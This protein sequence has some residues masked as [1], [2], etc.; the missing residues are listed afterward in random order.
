MR[1]RIVQFEGRRY[2]VKLEP[3]W[4]ERLED[5]SQQQGLRLNQLIGHVARN[6]TEEVNLTAAIRS[7]CLSRT[8]EQ[9]NRV[10]GEL[11]E[12]SLTNQGVPL[13][14]IVDACPSPTLMVSHNQSIQRAN[15]AAVQWLGIDAAALIGR[16]I[17]HYIQ[18]KSQIPLDKILQEFE[19][20]AHH[21]YHGRIVYLRPGRVVTARAN[22]CPG[23]IDPVGGS[24][25]LLLVDR[26]PG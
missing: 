25:F 3:I 18:I 10:E 20:G 11:E 8:L 22:I 13:G 9:L 1:H 15:Q 7:Y 14:L 17:G 12:R 19:N 5:L 6:A 23:V 2:S 26:G 16:M 24:S 21:V 4:W